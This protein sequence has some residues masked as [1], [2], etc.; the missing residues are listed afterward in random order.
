MLPLQV[1]D[2]ARPDSAFEVKDTVF[3]K[4][5]RDTRFDNRILDLRTPANQSIFKVRM[6]IQ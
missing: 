1:E 4:P 2:A 3:V 6:A 5:G